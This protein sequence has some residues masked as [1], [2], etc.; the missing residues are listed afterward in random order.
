[1][2]CIGHFSNGII[3][4]KINLSTIM[5]VLDKKDSGSLVFL[6]QSQKEK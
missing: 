6:V 3:Q 1:M 5:I 2:P 4:T